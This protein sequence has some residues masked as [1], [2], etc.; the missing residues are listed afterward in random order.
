MNLELI[1]IIPS[2]LIWLIYAQKRHYE[3]LEKKIKM[4]KN[5]EIN[6]G[7]AESMKEFQD[8]KKRVDVL[9]LKAGLRL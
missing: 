8:Y 2:I 9:T 1:L 7:L 4:E 5:F 6:S 3:Y